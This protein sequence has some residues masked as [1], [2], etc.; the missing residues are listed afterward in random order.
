MTLT[1]NILKTNG[2]RGRYR[3]MT[4]TLEREVVN[5]LVPRNIYTRGA[6]ILGTGNPYNLLNPA[7]VACLDVESTLPLQCVHPPGVD[8]AVLVT[9]R[10]TFLQ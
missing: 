1:I 8:S 2:R 10:D 5:K 3:Q 4:A 9:D 7:H 6:L